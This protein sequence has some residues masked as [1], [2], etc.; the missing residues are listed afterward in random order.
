MVELAK[1]DHAA[2][3]PEEL[4]RFVRSR[5]AGRGDDEHV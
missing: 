2:A 5:L 3:S 4:P 1:V